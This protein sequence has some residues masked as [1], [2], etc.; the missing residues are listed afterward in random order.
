MPRRSPEAVH[1][2]N[3][4]V[5][6]LGGTR[7]EAAHATR[8]LR[9]RCSAFDNCCTHLLLVL[10]STLDCEF[11]QR[12]TLLPIG[13]QFRIRKAVTVDQLLSSSLG[14]E[15]EGQLAVNSRTADSDFWSVMLPVNQC[16]LLQA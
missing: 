14:T 8:R 3:K 2:N 11:E 12:D 1:L 7:P 10:L 6:A 16:L 4:F 13:L 9:W 15:H 5:W